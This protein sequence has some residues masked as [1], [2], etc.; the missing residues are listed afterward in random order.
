MTDANATRWGAALSGSEGLG[1]ASC[2]PTERSALASSARD[3][4]PANSASSL[5]CCPALINR[6][7]RRW[8][9]LQD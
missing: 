7:L 3:Q 4:V 5:L 6:G 9:R 1:I 2:S 8:Q